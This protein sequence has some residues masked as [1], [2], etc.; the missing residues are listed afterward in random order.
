MK[1]HGLYAITPDRVEAARVARAIEGGIT[2]LQYRDKTAT[3]ESML[4]RAKEL[5]ALCRR[6]NVLFIVNDDVELAIACEADGVH[7]GRDDGE[8]AA[9][10]KKM[11][12]KLLGVSCYDSL[13]AARD[14]A[15]AGA[16][17]V[18]FGSVFPSPTKPGARR[19]PLSLFGEARALGVPLV[20]IGGVTLENAPQLLAAGADA[21]A[22]ISD[23]F[24]A[25]DVAARAR[26]YAR[27]FAHEVAQ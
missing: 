19:A 21:V 7:L 27:L 10:R 11:K 24:D 16:D 1:L 6:K 26:A 5:V 22:V 18:A 25:P 8:I 4:R 2:A 20:A 23:L 9:A 3:P 15:A 17:Y 12:R 14:A 13:A